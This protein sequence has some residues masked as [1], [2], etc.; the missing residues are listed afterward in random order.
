M[1]MKLFFFLILYFKDH[2]RS[3]EISRLYSSLLSCDKTCD[4]AFHLGEILATVHKL[5]G[6]YPFLLPNL[7][8]LIVVKMFPKT[9][10]IH[11]KMCSAWVRSP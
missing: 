8:A 5:R 3:P 11:S 9:K 2:Y 10:F 4:P 6:Y 7:A 1:L